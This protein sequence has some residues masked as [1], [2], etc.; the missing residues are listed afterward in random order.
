MRRG[1]LALRWPLLPAPPRAPTPRGLTWGTPH[2][3]GTEAEPPSLWPLPA[4]SF[5]TVLM[6]RCLFSCDVSPSVSRP[7]FSW[8]LSCWLQPPRG[9]RPGDTRRQGWERR[10]PA[11]QPAFKHPL[12]PCAHPAR[13]GP[14]GAEGSAAPG[15]E[16]MPPSTP[17]ARRA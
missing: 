9:T 7:C 3:R 10:A 2:S 12:L 8:C 15:G 14:R 4:S 5:R 6:Q 11:G 13:G 17:T 16:K 1:S